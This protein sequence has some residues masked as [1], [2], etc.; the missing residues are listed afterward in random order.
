MGTDKKVDKDKKESTGLN[1]VQKIVM[2]QCCG[3]CWWY[4]DDTRDCKA[5]VKF[6]DSTFGRCEGMRR[7][8]RPE[9]GI[10]CPTYQ[11]V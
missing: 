9:D 10:R 2:R 11:A 6:P 7:K 8:M 4:N 3:S 1:P 5:P